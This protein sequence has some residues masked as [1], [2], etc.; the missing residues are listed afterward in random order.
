M[1][2][3]VLQVSQSWME[4]RNVFIIMA[5]GW[6]VMRWKFLIIFLYRLGYRA[7]NCFFVAFFS[8]T[9]VTFRVLMFLACIMT[10]VLDFSNSFRYASFDNSLDLFKRLITWQCSMDS[11][12]IGKQTVF[13]SLQVCLALEAYTGRKRKTKICGGLRLCFIE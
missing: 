12:I 6:W 9:Y 4:W 8:L 13:F 5:N 11:I 10:T 1:W 7:F 2:D 3:F